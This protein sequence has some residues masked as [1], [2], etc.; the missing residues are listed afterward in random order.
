MS[1]SAA[2]AI[3][4]PLAHAARKTIVTVE[5]IH[6]GNLLADPVLAAG[7]LPELRG[8]A[9]AAA[10][11]GAWP[12]P[13]PNHYPADLDHLQNMRAWQRPTTVSPAISMSMSMQGR[14]PE[15]ALGG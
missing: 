11:N 13:L 12:L 8:I 10:E 3:L 15:A 2:S 14:Q 1:G 6:D 7:V 4:R 5:R 9:I